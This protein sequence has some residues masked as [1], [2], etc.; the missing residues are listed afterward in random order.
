M[1]K[2]IA[3]EYIK[4]KKL[5]SLFE[6]PIRGVILGPSGCGKNFLLTY[7]ILSFWAPYKNLYIFAKNLDQEVY[8]Y[9]KKV[10]ANIPS[11]KIHF[12]N[13][14]IISV[15]ECEPNSLVVFDDFIK[16]KQDLIIEYYIRSRSK[17]IHVLYLTQS[18]TSLDI[19][20]IRNNLNVLFV[21]NQSNYYIEKIWSDL[22]SDIIPL[23]KFKNIFRTYCKKYDN[24]TNK[25]IYGYITIDLVKNLIYDKNGKILN[26][27]D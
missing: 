8:D 23:K 12:S 25:N 27:D 19:K 4:V 10:F 9:I 7:L 16:E 18:F 20:T 6:C 11:V 5:E 13:N 17:N 24:N 3:K 1:H 14:E 15:D 2:V 26:N 22:V 21:F